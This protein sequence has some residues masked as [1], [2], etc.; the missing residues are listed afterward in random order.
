MGRYKMQKTSTAVVKS[1][2]VK[3]EGYK[4][5]YNRYI[6]SS[7]RFIMTSISVK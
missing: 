6:S 7:D 1:H 5:I 3:M 2:F 4:L